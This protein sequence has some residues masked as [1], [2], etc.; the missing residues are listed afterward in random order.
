MKPVVRAVLR[1]ALKDV[2]H[3]RAVPPDSADGLVSRVYAQLERDFGVLAP[4][5]A[6]HSPAPPALAAAWMLLRETLLVE[7]RVARRAK[8]VVATEVSRAN[9]CPYCVDVHQATL[10][11][12][13]P[14]RH[15]SG[16]AATAATADIAAW[17][18]ASGLRPEAE[19]G[20]GLGQGQ[21][22]E[23]RQ[24]QGQRQ[25]LS[26][27]PPFAAD[28]APEIYGVA[29]V[30]H[31]INRMVHLYLA[32]SPVPDQAPGF[33]RGT[34]LR[35]A[36]K[37]MRPADE[38]P[39]SPGASLAL[40]PPARLPAELGWA[41]G[42][43]HVA[44]AL[45]RAVATVSDG[46]RWVPTGVRESVEARLDRWDGRP[47]G[48]GRAWLDG[49]LADLPPADRPTARIALLTA[50]APYQVTDPDIAAFRERHPDDRELVELTSWAA[51]S[52][53][54]CVGG[55]FAADGRGQASGQRGQPA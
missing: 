28:A 8:E 1:G 19:P 48:L 51:L 55:R 22:Q 41:R 54:V 36:A 4:P 13:P 10:G 50:F 52:A 2:R 46:A 37:A 9:D 35:T 30:F 26:A 5:V 38:G 21:G 44:D 40:L 34:I 39:L 20:L 53:A 42:N 16:S 45:G 11:T 33:L 47:P 43:P 3:V 14:P 17:A 7:G 18:R 23:Q 27:P 6:L 49:A 12:L 31:Y 24:E 32:D 25:G 15:A 29:L